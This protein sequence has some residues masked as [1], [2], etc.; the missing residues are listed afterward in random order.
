MLRHRVPGVVGEDPGEVE[1]LGRV[2]RLLR[3]VQYGGRHAR[4]E[5]RRPVDG[6]VLDRHPVRVGLELERDVE[7]DVLLRQRLRH[8]LAEVVVRRAER[9]ARH[10]APLALAGQERV[11]HR[12]A[13]A[14]EVGHAREVVALE[15]ARLRLRP[16]ELHQRVEQV[17]LAEV[18]EVEDRRVLVAPR[19]QPGVRA[20][21]RRD[22]GR[23]R[24]ADQVLRALLVLEQ[25]RPRDAHELD[26]HAHEADVVDVAGDVRPRPREPDPG[27]VRAS[28]LGEDSPPH[29]LGE[30]VAHREL[31]ADDSVGLR[32]AAPLVVPGLPE[33]RHLRLERVDDR[34]EALLLVRLDALLGDREPFVGAPEVDQPGEEPRRAAPGAASPRPAG[35]TDRHDARRGRGR[36][37]LG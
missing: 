24:D 35:R 7:L 23:S 18:Q 34:L 5:P 14:E 12:L 4:R 9:E 33:P 8:R 32:V 15:R 37:P 29:V 25:L 21:V 22:E 19:L 1:L 6:V 2:E 36:C 30:I 17:W 16:E 26:A 11:L 13:L 10:P 27:A 28:R 20:R 31:G 3:D